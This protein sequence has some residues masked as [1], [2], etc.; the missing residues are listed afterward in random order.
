MRFSLWNLFLSRSPSPTASSHDVF[1][2]LTT[3][4][5]YYLHRSS[6]RLLSCISIPSLRFLLDLL[7]C[8]YLVVSTS[9][10]VDNLVHDC[11][12]WVIAFWH[13]QLRHVW[14]PWYTVLYSYELSLLD[15]STRIFQKSISVVYLWRQN[16]ITKSVTELKRLFEKEN[17]PKVT[18][19]DFYV[20]HTLKLLSNIHTSVFWLIWRVSH[21]F[22]KNVIFGWQKRFLS[23][24]P[25]FILD[26][27]WENLEIILHES[28]ICQ[29]WSSIFNE[30]NFSS[31]IK[32]IVFV[33][34]FWYQFIFRWN[35]KTL[36][37]SS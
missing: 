33:F 9:Q 19:K 4:V 29:S 7:F 21:T 5:L 31:F 8:F 2:H 22:S 24:H 11:P 14:L 3:V 26:T 15:F 27:R 6:G 1:L 10:Y 34:W 16:C 37:C 12:R 30:F 28:C 35:I 25:I 13:P 18:N 23:L 17:S 32:N 36:R 20:F